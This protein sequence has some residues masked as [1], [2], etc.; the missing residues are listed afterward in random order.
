MNGH[1]DTYSYVLVR[2]RPGHP[3]CQ[4]A[5]HKQSAHTA[6]GL[7]NHPALP[8][9]H[10]G[11]PSALS[12][13]GLRLCKHQLDAPR[14]LAVTTE[15][16]L[17]LHASDVP[18]CVHGVHDRV[19]QRAVAVGRDIVLR[20]P[21]ARDRSST[22]IQVAAWSCNCRSRVKYSH[23]R[24]SC[25]CCSRAKSAG[26]AGSAGGVLTWETEEA[27]KMI[28]SPTEASRID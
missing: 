28:P 7:D 25:N 20:L 19:G 9:P 18:G 8:P 16:R 12:D 6:Q 22:L 24:G 23:P 11:G 4:S 1:G 3:F 17:G 14:L 26:I 15:I 21:A 10:H 27:P 2:P 5:S 13:A